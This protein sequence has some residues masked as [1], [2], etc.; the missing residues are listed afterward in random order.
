MIIKK[1]CFDKL[2][3]ACEDEVLN[4]IKTSVVDKIVKKNCLIHTT[5]LMITSLLLV[6]SSINCFYNYRKHLL[7]N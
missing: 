7:K 4:K 3:S 1:A 5:L 2:V 6:V